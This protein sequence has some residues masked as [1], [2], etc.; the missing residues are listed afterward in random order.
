MSR[1]A[2]LVIHMAALIT[3]VSDGQ[4]VHLVKVAAPADGML[5][6]TDRNPGLGFEIEVGVHGYGIRGSVSDYGLGV[7]G[8]KR[9][10]ET[11]PALTIACYC[12]CR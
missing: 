2:R 6:L 8:Y 12:T 10:I 11:G 4:R 5:F 3:H 1:E 9:R 7:G